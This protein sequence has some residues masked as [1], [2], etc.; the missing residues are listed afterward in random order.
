MSNSSLIIYV[1][2]IIINLKWY[3]IIKYIIKKTKFDPNDKLELI[4]VR[5][6]TPVSEYCWVKQS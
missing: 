3:H 2:I 1:G 6:Y 4:N 5:Y